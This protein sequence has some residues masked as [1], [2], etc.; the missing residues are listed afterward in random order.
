MKLVN[1]IW[2]IHDNGRSSVCPRDEMITL[3]ADDGEREI[4]NDCRGAA[5]LLRNRG[6]IVSVDGVKCEE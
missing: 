6:G 1:V 5:R 2:V 3:A 4:A